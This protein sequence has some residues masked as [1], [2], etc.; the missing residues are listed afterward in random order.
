MTV[1]KFFPP[2]ASNGSH[3]QQQVVVLRKLA[4]ARFPEDDAAMA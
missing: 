4:L 1:A 2:R 3:Q